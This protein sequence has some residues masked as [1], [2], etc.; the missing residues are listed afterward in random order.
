MCVTFML[1]LL[2]FFND[3]ATTEIYTYGHTLSRHDAL[4]ISAARRAGRADRRAAER[5]FDMGAR[6]RGRNPAR[7]PRAW[8]RLRPLFAARPRFPDRHRAQPR[9][10]ARARL[11]AKRPALFG[12]ASARQPAHRRSD[13][14]GRREALRVERAVRTPLASRDVGQAAGAEAGGQEGVVQGG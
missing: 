10:T 11:A 6:G 4:P 5:I 8:H 2:F 9:R 3:P 1:V 7:L 14:R 12:R 13:R